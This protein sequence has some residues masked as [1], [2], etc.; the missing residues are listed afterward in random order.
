MGNRQSSMPVRRRHPSGSEI[1]SG[2]SSLKRI[3]GKNYYFENLV[4]EG[5]NVKSLAYVGALK[6]LDKVGILGKLKRFAGV[7]TS[8]VIASLLAADFDCDTVQRLLN[9]HI[10][11]LLFV[12]A[13]TPLRIRITGTL[14]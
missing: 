6:V 3:T 10:D 2:F 13:R 9:E 4:L 12:P 1:R 8:G 14:F 7:G 11:N 5:N